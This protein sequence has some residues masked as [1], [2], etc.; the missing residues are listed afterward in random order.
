[1]ID[2]IYVYGFFDG[3]GSIVCDH[4]KSVEIHITQAVIKPLE[5]IKE[6]YG[7]T[8]DIHSDGPENPERI[9]G[10]RRKTWR[11]KLVGYAAY[12]FLK[13]AYPYL[14]VKANRSKI[15]I[16]WWENRP[17]ER[18]RMPNEYYTE[19]KSKEINFRLLNMSAKEKK[20]ELNRRKKWLIKKG[21]I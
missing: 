18:D 2:K 9:N 15:A 10:V 17:R 3:E 4:S 16:E 1:M 12:K 5:L 11:W 8:I 19:M 14:I 20:L 13:D 7:G 6:R 21:Y